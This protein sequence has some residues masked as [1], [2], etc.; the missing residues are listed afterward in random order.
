MHNGSIMIKTTVRETIEYIHPAS[1]RE[2]LQDIMRLMMVLRETP[3]RNVD[4][5][6]LV[7]ALQMK[8]LK[9]FQVMLKAGFDPNTY[10]DRLKSS[11]ITEVLNLDEPKNFLKELIRHGASPNHPCPHTPNFTY[12]KQ[13]VEQ[14]DFDS[15]AL[16]AI[17]GADLDLEHRFEHSY[18]QLT[19]L[20]VAALTWRVNITEVLLLYGAKIEYSNPEVNQT[21]ALVYLCCMKKNSSF[22][23]K[24]YT[25]KVLHRHGAN[26]WQRNRQG[27]TALE[28]VLSQCKQNRSVRWFKLASVLRDCMRTPLSLQMLSRNA[29]RKNIGKM[30]YTKVRRLTVQGVPVSRLTILDFLLYKDLKSGFQ[31]EL[32][33]CCSVSKSSE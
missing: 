26:L 16:L 29:L 11:A 6:V 7:A 28:Y 3:V 18:K 27:K 33:E 12:V 23:H 2:E 10:D 15:V 14:G 32:D 5:Q 13:A 4:L 19:P 9:C 1:C 17:R 31:H 22:I 21:N 20:G 30:Y 25:L 24:L 8:H